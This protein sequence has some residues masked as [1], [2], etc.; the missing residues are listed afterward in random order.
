MTRSAASGVI[1]DTFHGFQ[2][3]GVCEPAADRLTVLWPATDSLGDGVRVFDTAVHVTAAAW[4]GPEWAHLPPLSATLQR[5]PCPAGWSYSVKAR[6][7][8]V[9]FPRQYGR[10]PE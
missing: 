7:C 8:V 4:G 5:A 10:P 1:S 6:A 3:S 2:A 9:C